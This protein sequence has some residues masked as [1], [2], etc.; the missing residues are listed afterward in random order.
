MDQPLPLPL[1]LLLPPQPQQQPR[2]PYK[3]LLLYANSIIAPAITVLPRVGPDE[4]APNEGFFIIAWL[5]QEGQ[6]INLPE[7]QRG[8]AFCHRDKVLM[9]IVYTDAHV[10]DRNPAP[11]DYQTLFISW[12]DVQQ[13]SSLHLL[14]FGWEINPTII[15]KS[16]YSWSLKYGHLAARAVKHTL[17]CGL[18]DV[19][20]RVSDVSDCPINN[21]QVDDGVLGDGEVLGMTITV[22]SKRVE[23]KHKV[24]IRCTFIC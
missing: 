17:R 2:V 22:D 18:R 6:S 20:L 16:A 19:I 24:Q 5:Y 13:C 23:F 4:E 9:L 11:P 15:P 14:L 12:P 3:L 7:A 1:P 10:P 8:F 21:L